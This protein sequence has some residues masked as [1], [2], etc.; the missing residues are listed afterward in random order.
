MSG[1][2][3][4]AQLLRSM[5]PVARPGCFVFASGDNV[6]PGV[7]VLASVVEEEGLSV[8]I[9]QEDADRLGLAYD[10]VA[11]WITLR[12]HS[13]L[14]AVGLTAAVSTSLAREQISCNVVAGKNH[15][16]LLV[17]RDRLDDALA[18]L[19]ALSTNYGGAQVWWPANP[20]Q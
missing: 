10:F 4:L 11:A 17:P 6:P 5:A 13:A 14:E 7:A 20:D 1:E 16:H 8:V 3:D 12:V 9:A 15:D 19:H 2:T 18:V